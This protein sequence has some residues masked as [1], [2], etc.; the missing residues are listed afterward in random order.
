ML[1]FGAL[2][3]IVAFCWIVKERDVSRPNYDFL[4]ETQ[5]AYS[6]AYDSFSPNPNFPDGIT[7]RSPP[8]G[9][10]ARGHL[11]LHYQPTYEDALRAGQEL[12]N[13]FTQNDASRRERGSAV[14]ANYCQVCH[15]TTGEGNGPITQA[16][17]PPPASLLADRAVQMKDGQMFH[18]LTYGQLNMPA[19]NA[20]LSRADRWSVILYV[21]MLQGPAAPS[22]VP[23]R[24]QEVARLFRENCAACHGEDGSGNNLRK[25]WPLLPDFT[26]LAWQMSQTETALVN[27]IHYGSHPLMP[28]FRFKLSA[29]QILRLAVYVRSLAAH[30]A[31]P[32]VSPSTNMTA[33][34]VFGTHCFVCHDTTGRGNPLIRPAMP[35]VPDFTA[36]AWQKSRTDADLAQSILLGKGKFM[37]PMADK[38]GTVDIKQIVA[39][40][41]GFQGGKQVIPLGAPA[42]PK[43]FAPVIVATPSTPTPSTDLPV[44]GATIVA[45]ISSPTGQGPVLAA[46]ALSSRSSSLTISST[47]VPDLKDEQPP[48]IPSDEATARMRIGENIFRQYCFVCHDLDGKGTK[49]RSVLPPIPDFTNAAWHKERSDAQLRVSILEGKGT[50]MPANRGRVT[51]EQA[52]DL[53]AFIRTFGPAKLLTG[54]TKAVDSDFWKSFRQLEEQ[55]DQ[56]TKELQKINAQR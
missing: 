23:S 34:N 32:Q 51:E 31:F 14:F 5:M 28:A 47:P 55:C 1:L 4:P 22:S 49:M 54:K 43:P 16:G 37:R 17:F 35:E 46:F 42:G 44:L 7:L 45:S 10:I 25:V 19:F 21:R 8:A 26:N 29:D 48:P 2:M 12:Q 38:L 9:T 33:A 53:V 13:P 27:Q 40:V 18:V 3:S 39:L 24:S 36:V 41:R 52:G 15:G 30:P 11:P 6:V 50:M 20:Q 56:L